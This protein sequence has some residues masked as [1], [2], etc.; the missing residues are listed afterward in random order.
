MGPIF[1]AKEFIE[2]SLQPVIRALAAVDSNPNHYTLAGCVLA[3][4]SPLA[5]V[6]GHPL[7]SLLLMALSGAFDA[8]DGMVARYTGRAS[9]IGSILDSV[10][11]R[12]S[13]SAYHLT[14]LIIGIDP[15][16]V[17]ASLGGALT[18][19]YVRAKGEAIGIKMAGRGVLER[20]ERTLL[21]LAV[22]SLAAAGHSGPASYLAALMAAL[23]WVTVAQRLSLILHSVKA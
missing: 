14:L 2:R 11:D 9:R 5:A 3:I 17:V 19:P 12:V 13:D 23:S 1:R 21:I 10:L 22:A 20:P 8:I 16:V 4:A 7:V 6:A 15:V 18:T